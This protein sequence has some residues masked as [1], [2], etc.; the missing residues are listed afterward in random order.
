MNNDDFTLYRVRL[1]NE[2]RQGIER[3]THQNDER[4]CDVYSRLVNDFI[5]DINEKTYLLSD[6]KSSDRVSIWIERS[7]SDR[8]VEKADQYAM[9]PSR[10]VYT[11]I[12]T[13]LDRL[14]QS[15]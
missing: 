11:A 5:N 4:K 3:I 6:S 1:S 15:V 9:T 7:V 13:G 10:I 12:T 8:L 14:K 2:Q